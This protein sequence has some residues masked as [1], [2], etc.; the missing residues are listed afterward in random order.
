MDKDQHNRMQAIEK[1]E[2]F[3]GLELKEI[4][5][6]L[7]AC[8]FESLEAG[9][10][11]YKVDEPSEDMFILLKGQLIV[12]GKANNVLGSIAPGMSTGEMGLFTGRPRSAN[13]TAAAESTGLI[14]KKSELVSVF[15]ENSKIHLKVLQNVV[16]LLS[17]R[18]VQADLHMENYATEIGEL[19]EEIGSTMRVR[20]ESTESTE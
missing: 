7:L 3:K 8:S 11:L 17:K 16:D 13:V 10:P 15:A 5:R 9:H 1:V 4:Q 18:L 6:L 2:V 19:K 14:V 20:G 12:T